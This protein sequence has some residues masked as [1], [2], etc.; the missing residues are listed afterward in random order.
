MKSSK[1][2]TPQ[3]EEFHVGFEFEFS[4]L[5]NNWNKQ[6]FTSQKVLREESEYFGLYTLSWV[7]KI[8]NN[9]DMPI[10]NYMRVKYLDSV[11]IESFEF[12]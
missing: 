8:F 9:K 2:Y 6:P 3:I 4:G 1:Y 12:I 5:D 7:K 11:D 10:E